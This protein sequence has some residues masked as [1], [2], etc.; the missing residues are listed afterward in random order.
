VKA[1]NCNIQ[2]KYIITYHTH[3]PYTDNGKHSFICNS[4]N[5][6]QTAVVSSLGYT[7]TQALLVPKLNHYRAIEG[8]FMWHVRVGLSASEMELSDYFFHGKY[9]DYV[10]CIRVDHWVDQIRVLA[11]CQYT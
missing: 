10:T 5:C 9:H 8:M 1:V 3:L 7:L 4:H 11:E 2:S 6:P